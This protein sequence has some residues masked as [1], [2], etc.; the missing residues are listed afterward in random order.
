MKLFPP[1][2]LKKAEEGLENCFQNGGRTLQSNL[3]IMYRT[4]PTASSFHIDCSSC[5]RKNLQVL[6]ESD[7]RWHYRTSFR[8]NDPNSGHSAIDYFLV[9]FHA[10]TNF[11][12]YVRA[13]SASTLKERVSSTCC[14]EGRAIPRDFRDFGARR[15]MLMYAYTTG[16]PLKLNGEWFI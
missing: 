16:S 5:T 10:L 11:R 1:I 12:G 8:K 7:K 13:T 4:V 9:T 6:T 3:S 2:I 14:T 15:K